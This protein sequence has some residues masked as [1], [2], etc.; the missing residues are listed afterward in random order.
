MIAGVLAVFAPTAGPVVGGW[1]TATYSWPWLFLINVAPG[2]VAGAI[3]LLSLPKERPAFAEARRLDV[4]SLALIATAL[5]SLEIA[6]KEAPERGWTSPLALGLLA[7]SAI[8]ALGFVV[9]TL[10]R[11][12]TAGRAAHL[13]RPQLFHRLLSELHVRHGVIR[14]GLSDAGFSRLRARA[15]RPRDRRDHAGDR[16]FAAH[17][18]PAR[19]ACGAADRRTPADR[20][21][22]P[23]FCHRARHEHRA[24]AGDRLCR[25]VLAAGAARHGHHVLHSAAD[26]SWRS[27]NW[28]NPRSP[29]PAPCST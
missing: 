5:A 23:A 3:A 8:A 29:T 17:R 12:Q 10:R 18:R 14:L 25:H 24:D 4:I 7:L 6:I 16:R 22:L 13:P 1:I 26:H 21:R 27:A 9:A 19:H 20:F 28:R 11:G 15:Q 2:I